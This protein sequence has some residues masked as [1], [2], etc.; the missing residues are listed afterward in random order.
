MSQDSVSPQAGGLPLGSLPV[1]VQ[2]R[3]TPQFPPEVVAALR[4]IRETSDG[5]YF[6]FLFSA[7]EPKADPHTVWLN[8]FRGK[9]W[10]PDWNHRAYQQFVAE[11]LKLTPESIERIFG[12]IV[13]HQR[14]IERAAT[15]SIPPAPPEA[16]VFNPPGVAPED[17]L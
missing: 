14:A 12:P 10:K 2:F 5:R 8:A 3:Q 4:K 1:G 17:D 15:Q 11:L 6:L 7:D 16:V 13:D 9:N